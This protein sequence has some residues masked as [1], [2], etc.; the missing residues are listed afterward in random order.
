M[1]AIAHRGASAYAPEN[2]MAAFRR[3]AEMGARFIETDLRATRD[4]RV[5]A[6]HDATVN[7]TTNG[8]GR[9]DA[10]TLAEVR[11]LD[12]GTWFHWN[13]QRPFAGERVPT[14]DEVLQF[15]HDVDVACYLE[16]KQARGWGIENAVV[17]ALQQFKQVSHSVVISFDAAVLAAVRRIDPA[18]M[19]G[20][21]I[22]RVST[23]AIQ[24]ALV[25][26][27]RQILPRAS[28]VTPGFVAAAHRENLLAVPWTANETEEMKTLAQAGVD[29]MITDYPDR[30]ADV[31]RG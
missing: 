6:I 3:A 1:W 30:L 29:G 25:A 26:G 16:L 7:R 14:L 15:A 19:T 10:M 11:D 31:L 4:A 22:E 24:K 21:L 12:A 28:R 5:V 17:A 23:R 27:V 8:T 2:T 18:V 20:L 9:V 13:G